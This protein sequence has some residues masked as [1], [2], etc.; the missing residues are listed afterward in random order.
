MKK[1]DPVVVPK[2]VLNGIK[3]LK[4]VHGTCASIFFNNRVDM[5]LV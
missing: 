3:I 4:K 2:S 1:G 5:L